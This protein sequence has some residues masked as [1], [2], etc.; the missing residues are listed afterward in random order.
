MEAEG[1]RRKTNF[2]CLVAKGRESQGRLIDAF[3][4]YQEFA[5]TSQSDDLISV[6]DEPSVRA[7]GE[8]WS[9]GRI[10][11]MVAKASP[12]NKKPLE[13]KIQSTWDQLQKKAQRLMS[14]RSLLHFRVLF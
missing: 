2:L 12:E 14:L 5:A 9:Q 3:D 11:A 6:L 13:A 8:V 10:A 4:K 1:R 7:S